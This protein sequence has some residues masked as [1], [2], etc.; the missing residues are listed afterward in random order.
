[1]AVDQNQIFRERSK[2]KEGATILHLYA[3]DKEGIPNGGLEVYGDIHFR[4]GISAVI[5]LPKIRP[6]PAP[7]CG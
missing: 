4:S 6:A 2:S 3:Q 5:S 1:V 7:G